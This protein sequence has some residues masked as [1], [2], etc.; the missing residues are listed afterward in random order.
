MKHLNLF[1]ALFMVAAGMLVPVQAR[2][3][4]ITIISLIM[5]VLVCIDRETFFGDLK[6]GEKDEK[7]A[8]N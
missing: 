2:S 6:G 4:S 8:K 7:A 3:I 5:V 1:L